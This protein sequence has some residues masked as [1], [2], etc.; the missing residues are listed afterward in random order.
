[1]ILNSNTILTLEFLIGKIEKK[2]SDTKIT[3]QTCI[4]IHTHTYIHTYK[5]MIKSPQVMR[6]PKFQCVTYPSNKEWNIYIHTHVHINCWNITGERGDEIIMIWLINRI[7]G[8]QILSKSENK[9]VTCAY[10]KHQN[11]WYWPI[12]IGVI[13][14][15]VGWFII[16]KKCKSIKRS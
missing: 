12:L 4:I 16:I 11:W 15:N 14:A 3:T 1:M 7:M 6:N 8:Y 9:W 13:F 5:L 10:T 2:N